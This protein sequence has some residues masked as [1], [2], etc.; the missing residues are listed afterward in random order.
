MQSFLL[1][2]K[3][4]SRFDFP[5]LNK[6]IYRSSYDIEI[7]FEFLDQDISRWIFYLFTYSGQVRIQER[8]RDRLGGG[9][10]KTRSLAYEGACIFG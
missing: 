9:G 6:Y 10:F 2:V 1:N 8:I 4:D 7:Q 5:P 3:D